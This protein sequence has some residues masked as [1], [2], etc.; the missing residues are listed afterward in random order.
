MCKFIKSL[1]SKEGT[2]LNQEN[3][4]LRKIC[5]QSKKSLHSIGLASQAAGETK[6]CAHLSI[7]RR[8]YREIAQQAEQLLRQR[9]QRV[10]GR[11]LPEIHG[12]SRTALLEYH[13]KDCERGFEAAL[14]SVSAMQT[15]D[16]KVAALNRSLLLTYQADLKGMNLLL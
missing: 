5:R 11:G 7:Q 3:Q 1:Y 6:L 12:M 9:G 2:T 10:P 14:F 13:K 4:L 16:P 15:A 8:H